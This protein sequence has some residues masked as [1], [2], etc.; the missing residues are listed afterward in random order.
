MPCI[1]RAKA[2]RSHKTLKRSGA[3]F[4]NRIMTCFHLILKLAVVVNHNQQPE[5]NKYTRTHN[6]I[7]INKPFT[8]QEQQATELNCW[9]SH[10][11]FDLNLVEAL[12]NSGG[13]C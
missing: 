2:P 8:K 5:M 9:A 6:K 12:T 7:K 4:Y 13:S 1:W 10:K 11:R 3:F